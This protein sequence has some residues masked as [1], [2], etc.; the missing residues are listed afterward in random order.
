M[1]LASVNGHVTSASDATIPVVDS[2]VTHADGA[3]E[4][5][6]VY[7]GHPFELSGHLDRLA[8]SVRNL[9]LGFQIDTEALA[10]EAKALLAERGAGSFE[11]C[12]RVV[13][14]AGGNRLLM[15][16]PVP[17]W[18]DRAHL[19]SVTYSPTWILDGVKSLSY[20]PNMLAGRI[21]KEQ[22]GNEA[23]LV[24]PHGIVLEAP[25]SSIFYVLDDGVLS[26][27]PL[28]EHILPSITRDLLVRSMNVRER[29]VTRDEILEASEAF[30]AST[31]R[32]VQP[33]AAIDGI[34]LG[35]PGSCT[36]DAMRA[37]RSAIEE[38]VRLDPSAA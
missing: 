10:V 3:F 36:R 23:L 18:P 30:L 22:G 4:V 16:E 13:I 15:T 2:G 25:T 20:A 35:E 1:E 21:A 31:T 12:L 37:L 38:A 28:D 11:G 33:V 7:R 32:E 14:T 5:I 34:E 19:V 27:P 24:T 17:A 6:R 26:T 29:R 9:R 8:L